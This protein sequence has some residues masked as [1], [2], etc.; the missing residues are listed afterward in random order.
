VYYVESDIQKKLHK[1]AGFIKHYSGHSIFGEP[2]DQKQQGI[3]RVIMNERWRSRKQG[4]I[5]HAAR[6]I[7]FKKS[8]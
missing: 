3:R 8:K 4:A 6:K 5:H 2:F 7:V 1:S